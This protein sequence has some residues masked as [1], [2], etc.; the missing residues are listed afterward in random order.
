MLKRIAL[1][2]ISSGWRVPQQE[3]LERFQ[4]LVMLKRLLESL[5]INCVLDV[6]ANHG[7][8]AQELRRIGFSG[9]IISF[10]PVRSEFAL[11]DKSFK[12]DTRW[13]GYQVALGS[14]DGSATIKVPR[15]TVLS[16]LLAPIR[17][18][19]E[20]RLEP[21]E[22]RRLD[23]LFRTVTEAVPNPR[24]LLKM[25]T[26]G[27]D[28]EVFNGAAGCLDSICALQSEISIQPLYRGMPHYLDALRVY[29]QAGFELHD[30]TVVAR[31]GNGCLQELN[32]FM[33]RPS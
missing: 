30:L 25:D 21:V 19:P 31:A 16:S 26:Q 23:G 15:L 22:I 28:L 29:E 10:E 13:S 17:D 6:G 11:L 2:L 7:Q 3:R 5:A 24:V 20:A 32:C 1:R 9:K 14:A 4:E 18:D 8:Y 12:D 33:V 27:Y